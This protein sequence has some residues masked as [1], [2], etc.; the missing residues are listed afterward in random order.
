MIEIQVL[1]S[2]Y[3]GRDFLKEQLDSIFAQSGV[4]VRVLA[5]DDGSD[6]GTAIML[7]DYARS[8]H[9]LLE[10]LKKPSG[11]LGVIKSY[12]ALLKNS[13]GRILAFA[14]QDDVWMSDKLAK[15]YE[16]LRLIEGDGAVPAMVYSDLH[17]VSEDLASIR[18]SFY[19]HQRIKARRAYSVKRLTV[20]NSVVGCTMLFNKALVDIAL[21]FPVSCRMHDWWLALCAAGFGAVSFVPSSTVFYRQHS[22][23]AVGAQT[24]SSRLRS[25][26]RRRNSVFLCL[27]QA[28]ALLERNGS[29]PLADEAFLRAIREA[30]SGAAQKALLLRYGAVKDGFPRNLFFFLLARAT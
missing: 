26:W 2:T 5:R 24:F 19:D 12:E 22:G 6:D 20:Q 23:N 16:A 10:I 30:K 25:A 28:T 3:N 8:S 14:D 1:L 18:G 7:E 29:R 21:P 11:N 4:S 9:G 27:S 15:S 17:V 13:D